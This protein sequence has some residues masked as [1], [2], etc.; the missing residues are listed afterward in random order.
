MKPHSKAITQISINAHRTLLIT[1]GQD[2]T[3]FMYRLQLGTPFTLERLGFIETP[4]NVAYMTWKPKEVRTKTK[5]LI[6]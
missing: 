3:I 5:N 2:C 4:N 1:C 6:N